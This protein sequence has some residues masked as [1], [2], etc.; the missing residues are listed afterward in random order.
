MVIGP[1]TG[2]GVS[3]QSMVFD[4]RPELRHVALEGDTRLVTNRERQ[5]GGLRVTKIEAAAVVGGGMVPDER[6][7]QVLEIVR[8]PEGDAALASTVEQKDQVVTRFDP[9]LLALPAAL[10]VGAR[11]TQDLYVRV[12]PI[13]SPERVQSQGKATLT[14]T[15]EAIERVRVPA[16]E[17]DAARVESVLRIDLGTAKVTVT[18]TLWYAAGVG[19]VAERHREKV[20]VFG[21]VIRQK[22]E[23]WGLE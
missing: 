9:P 17:F 22:A 19:L 23:A 10:A 3:A 4:V 2:A 21:V 16:G 14:L 11:R 8:T 20:T 15:C 5:A 6:T 18:T 13:A 12:F 1:A 7:R